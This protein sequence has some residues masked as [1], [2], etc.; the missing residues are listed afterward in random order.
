MSLNFKELWNSLHSSFIIL[1][2]Y[3]EAVTSRAGLTTRQTR[4]SAYDPR[5]KGGLQ[6]SNTSI[7]GPSRVIKEVKT[8]KRG[9]IKHKIK[10]LS[11]KKFA[12]QISKR[13][14]TL[15]RP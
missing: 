6:R 14:K 10:Q 2:F 1:S 3:L 13:K 12:P 4:Q 8:R 11:L 5:G 9:P 15:I 7:K